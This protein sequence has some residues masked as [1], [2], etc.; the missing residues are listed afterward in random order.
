MMRNIAIV[1]HPAFQLLDAAGPTAAF[2]M[3]E[4]FR[5]GSYQL[6]VMAPG[7]CRATARVESSFGLSFAAEPLRDGPFDTILVSGGEIIRS[8]AAAQQ[9]V[10]WA[11]ERDGPAHRQRLLGRFPARRGQPPQALRRARA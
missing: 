6:R 11:E 3:A 7:I 5:P 1:L 2:E 4:R 10:A 9:I 8:M